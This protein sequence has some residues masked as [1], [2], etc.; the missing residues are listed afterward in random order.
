[1]RLAYPD[2]GHE[3][4]FRAF[5]AEFEAAEEWSRVA[6]A[7]SRSF[8]QF[9]EGLKRD[10]VGDNLPPGIVPMSTMWLMS[11]G[12]DI[13]GELR[14]RHHLNPALEKE[15]GHIGYHIRPSRRRQGLGKL[16]L[17]LG[18]V[19]AQARGLSRVLVTC[20]DDNEASFKV[21]EAN[22]GSA[23]ETAVSELSGK[24]IRRYWIDLPA[25]RI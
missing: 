2:L 5:A 25:T 24:L 14:L 13:L 6:G 10:E 11:E 19:E 21:I 3:T 8:G 15:G 7:K 12:G 18:L 20:D 9:I 1:M 17:K 23:Y 4:A 16:I 22:G